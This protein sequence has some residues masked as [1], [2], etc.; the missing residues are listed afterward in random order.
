M[1][2]TDATRVP[3]VAVV[4]I[5]GHGGSH[6]RRVRELAATGA[7]TLCALVDPR[8]L[9]DQDAPATGGASGP[10]HGADAD[11]SGVAWFPTLGD[12]LSAPEPDLRPD[13]VILS[14]PIPT[15]L[16][17]ATVAMRAGVDVL[18]E[19]PTTA[20]LAEHTALAAV[21]EETGR[22]C[23][24]GFQTF[25]SHA[26]GAIERLV[27]DDEIGEV[28]GVGA[29]GLWVRTV[30]YWARAPWAGRRQLDGRDVVDGVVTNP[31]AHAVATG[32]R[33]AGAT[34]NHDVQ[35]VVVDLYHAND[36][37]ADDTSAV[38][39]LTADG[40]RCGFGLTLCA[41]ERTPARVIIHGTR[42]RIELA[43]ETDRVRVVTPTMDV[44]KHYGRMDLLED[45][46]AS[47]RTPGRALACDVR[48]TG[49][50]MRVMEAVRTAPDPRP[51][52]ESHI[53]WVGEGDDRHPVVGDIERWCED[54]A[55]HARTFAELHAPWT[56]T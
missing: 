42:G 52:A 24:V 9:A 45:L 17:L 51:I 47:R 2:D 13:V 50:F 15:H 38:R 33:L 31:L 46:L 44:E 25:G 34:R 30:G 22:L 40:V 27:A 12:L 10:R 43:Y 35:D 29:V 19:K 36:I 54:V 48:D 41:A 5:H 39:V 21:A 11:G 28:T 55:L 8:P 18:L 6:V 3:R 16:P 14:T 20:S 37:E 26:I 1:T 53:E 32:L 56:R 23:Q 7:V 4:G 49:A